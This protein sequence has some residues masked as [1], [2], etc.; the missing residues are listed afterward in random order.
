M[1]PETKSKLPKNRQNTYASCFTVEEPTVVPPGRYTLTQV[2]E[3]VSDHHKDKL[4]YTAEVLA[5]RLQID[6]K[7]M[8]V[9]IV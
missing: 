9:Y 4:T 8:G 1:Y 2:I 6:V 7:L 3:C 5:K